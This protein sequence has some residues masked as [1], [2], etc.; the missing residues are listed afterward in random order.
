MNLMILDAETGGLDADA[1]PMVELGAALFNVEHRALLW[2]Y[3]TLLHD[4]RPNEAVHINGN[5]KVRLLARGLD[6]YDF[7]AAG[8]RVVTYGRPFFRRV[9]RYI[10]RLYPD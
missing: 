1:H 5:V 4:D 2:A 10:L 8:R 7:P 6:V 3:S 9:R